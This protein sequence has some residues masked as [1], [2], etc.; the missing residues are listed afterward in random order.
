MKPSRSSA[1]ACATSEAIAKF[2]HKFPFQAYAKE[3]ERLAN[4]VEEHSKTDSVSL[5]T[6]NQLVAMD[7]IIGLIRTIGLAVL[8]TSTD[9]SQESEFALES[10]V[11]Y[12]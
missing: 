6:L 1:P 10:R 3:L 8:V 4:V 12:I 5:Q 9:A 2:A 11:G 7:E